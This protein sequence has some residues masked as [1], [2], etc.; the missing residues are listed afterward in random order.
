[1]KRDVESDPGS[2]ADLT[3]RARATLWIGDKATGERVGGSGAQDD[4]GGAE[5]ARVGV[6]SRAGRDAAWVPVVFAVMHLAW[7]AGFLTGCAR[8]GVPVAALRS[9][10][11]R[12][13][14]SR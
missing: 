9:T 5:G 1:M 12:A 6:R 3:A 4:L 14:E 2:Q 11:Q 8:F 10:L 13:L 7:G